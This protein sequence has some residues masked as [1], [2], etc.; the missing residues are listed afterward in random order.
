MELKQLD[1]NEFYRE[2]NAYYIKNGMS[3]PEGLGSLILITPKQTIGVYNIPGLDNSKEMVDGLGSHGETLDEVLA[4]IY[5]VSLEKLGYKRDKQL[6]D[7]IYG[8]GLNFIVLTLIN[9]INL[10]SVVIEI[11]KVIN[12]VKENDA[13]IF[14]TGADLADS[15]SHLPELIVL[16]SLLDRD[17]LKSKI[18]E[19]VGV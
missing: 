17:E 19:K 7:I 18:Q 16:D 6:N 8:R 9:E 11:P 4:G 13:D 15:A 12:L 3:V 5:N 10:R 14:I 1:I 2:E